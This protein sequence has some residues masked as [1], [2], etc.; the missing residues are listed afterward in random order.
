M[1]RRLY[2]LVVRL[3][4]YLLVIPLAVLVLV[5]DSFNVIDLIRSGQ[6]SPWH[7]S[8]AK[9]PSVPTPVAAPPAAP[10]IV[11][12]AAPPDGA[13]RD[14][15]PCTPGDAGIARER[16]DARIAAWLRIVCSERGELATG[17]WLPLAQ[18]LAQMGQAAPAAPAA[19]AAAM[20]ALAAAPAAEP[21]L[22]AWASTDASFT[23]FSRLSVV[24]AGDEL[25]PQVTMLRTHLLGL[26]AWRSA[27]IEQWTLQAGAR[28]LDVMLKSGDRPAQRLLILDVL[29]R[30]A[31]R[32]VIGVIC[33]PQ[34][35]YDRPFMLMPLPDTL[36]AEPAAAG[37]KIEAGDNPESTGSGKH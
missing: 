13:V 36:R 31:D 12:P 35:L 1:P 14:T 23:G 9:A 16:M 15:R 32:P 5:P 3:L 19:H 26:D 37:V 17:Y 6:W 8:P 27:G 4:I 29:S 7:D 18:T 30:K 28:S 10:A 21:Y 25:T 33:N 20:T 2:A 11:A 34:C 22:V 24:A